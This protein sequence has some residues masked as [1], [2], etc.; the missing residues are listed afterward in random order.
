[1]LTIA[2]AQQCGPDQEVHIQRPLL[3]ERVGSRPVLSLRIALLGLGP[4]LSTAPD[5]CR[6]GQLGKRAFADV[7]ADHAATDLL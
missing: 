6:A 5:I 4:S 1:V 3:Q 7:L 2:C